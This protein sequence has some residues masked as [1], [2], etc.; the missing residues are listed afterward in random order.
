MI[1]SHQSSDAVSVAHP[2]VAKSYT[3]IGETHQPSSYS[4]GQH[5]GIHQENPRY[6]HRPD[7]I[8]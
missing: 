3:T 8:Q 2:F 4:H 5:V 6:L 7:S 1:D